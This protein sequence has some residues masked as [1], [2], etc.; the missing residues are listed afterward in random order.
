MTPAVFVTGQL[1]TDAVWAP[2]LAQWPD[3]DVVFADH[4][5]DD[6]IAGM[7]VRLLA[8]APPHF[9]LIAHAMG[10]SSRSR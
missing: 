5:R 9:D 6:T 4:A 2:M 3:R 8:A 7:A 10:A 1:L